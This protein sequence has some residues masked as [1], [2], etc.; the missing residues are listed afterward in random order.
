MKILIGTCKHTV[1]MEK[2]GI[3]YRIIFKNT[4]NVPL[5]PTDPAY[6]NSFDNIYRNLEKFEVQKPE[7]FQFKNGRD[8]EGYYFIQIYK[9]D[10]T[11]ANTMIEKFNDSQVVPKIAKEYMTDILTNAKVQ[12]NKI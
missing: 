5:P 11:Y 7:L 9:I 6:K 4:N 1:Q 2:Q 3:T 12:L 10:P 8:K